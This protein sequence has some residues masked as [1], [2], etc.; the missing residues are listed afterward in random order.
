MFIASLM[1]V[2]HRVECCFLSKDMERS[3][4]FLW[5]K[6]LFHSSRIFYEKRGLANVVQ[7]LLQMV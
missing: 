4:L 5:K 2:K 7:Y 3:Y 1:E 6:L